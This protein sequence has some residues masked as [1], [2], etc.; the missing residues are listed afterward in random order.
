MSRYAY[1]LLP[2]ILLSVYVSEVGSI[3]CTK[4]ELFDTTPLICPGPYDPKDKVYCCGPKKRRFC[5]SYAEYASAINTI[6]IIVGVLVTAIVVV[7]II[8]VVSC[9]CCSCC[10][11]AKR[12]NRRGNS[13]SF[14]ASQP[15]TTA[16]TATA[17]YSAQGAYPIQTFPTGYPQQQFQQ[18]YP[19]QQFTQEHFQYPTQGYPPQPPYPMAAGGYQGAYP[20][21]T[22]NP[23]PYPLNDQPPYNP[24]F[25]K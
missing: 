4:E 1:V 20:P 5:C 14:A 9:F 8:V 10:L 22:G 16:T 19:Q 2:V 13:T 25:G 24:S 11:L 18:Q 23:P 15:T 17:H 12:C 21:P 6:G 7:V 3:V